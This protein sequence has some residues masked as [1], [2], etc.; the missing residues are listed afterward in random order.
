MGIFDRLFGGAGK[1]SVPS[2]IKEDLIRLNG[3]EVGLG[4]KAIAYVATG[5]GGT[6]LSTLAVKV[7]VDRLGVQSSHHSNLK[8]INERR[9]FLQRPL[10]IEPEVLGRYGEVLAASVRSSLSNSRWIRIIGTDEQ[11]LPLRIILSEALQV[12][13]QPQPIVNIA[14]QQP[15]LKLEDA[16]AIA[17][18]LGG[19]AS[20]VYAIL[21]TRADNY[22]S[23]T[24]WFRRSVKL[25]ERAQSDPAGFAAGIL[26]TEPEG[27]V[28][29]FGDLKTWGLASMPEYKPI[30][31]ASLGAGS[32]KLRAAAASALGT[33]PAP[34]LASLVSDQLAN[35]N[36]DAR[37]TAVDIA[38]GNLASLEETLRAH[39]AVEK[40]ARV[41]TAIENLLHASTINAQAAPA[42]TEVEYAPEVGP[43]YRGVDGQWIAIPPMVPPPTEPVPPLTADDR[44]ELHA[45][46]ARLNK[47]N[48]EYNRKLSAEHRKH[49]W[50]LRKSIS[51]SQV[52]VMLALA[53]GKPVASDI[54]GM[55]A[56]VMLIR[57]SNE[58][59]SWLLAKIGQLPAGR[60]LRLIQ[61]FRRGVLK[62]AGPYSSPD[63]VL[64][65]QWMA[66]AEG[67]MRFIEAIA[68]EAKAPSCRPW[69]SSGV[70]RDRKAARGD[71]L[72]AALERYGYYALRTIPDHAVWPYL[73][74]HLDIL[75]EAF[76]GNSALNK[77]KAV[78]LLAKLPTLPVQFVHP[79]LEMAT[80][81]SKTGKKLA[82]TLV[83]SVPGLP[84]R[85]C[86][87]LDESRQAVRAGAADWIAERGET[88]AMPAL[89]K[90]L[91]KEKSEIARGAIIRALQQ[92]GDPLD[93][94]I[95]EAALIAEAEKGVASGKAKLPDWLNL[96]SAP[97]VTFKSGK[98]V[99]QVV[100]H[101][102][103]SLANK[104]KDP[105]ATRL[106]GLWLDQLAPE[107][108]RQ[109]STWVLDAWIDWD[110]TRPSLEEANAYAS[111][112]A[113]AHYD[114]FKRWYKDYT[115]ELAHAQLRRERLAMM[116]NSSVDAKGLLALACRA[117]PA[118]VAGKVRAFLKEFGQRTSQSNS[119][120]EMLSGI[121]HPAA[122]QVVL[123]TSMRIKQKSVQ[124][125]AGD[126]VQAI[127][128][129][130]G[131]TI[132]E[133]ADRTI[134]TAGF[135][136]SGELELL[137]GEDAKRYCA[138]LGDDLTIL[139][140]NPAGKTVSSLPSG[141]DS[142]S[143]ESKKLLSSAR[144]ELKQVITLQ[145][146]RLYE[147]MCASR[148]FAA[149]D[150]QTYFLAHPIMRKL[151]VRTVWEGLDSDGN[152]LGAFRPTIEG[153][154]TDASDEA[155]DLASFASVRLAHPALMDPASA[156]DWQ[157]HLQD[158]EITQLFTQFGRP[159]H[160]LP[161]SDRKQRALT[162]R[163]G[164]SM[165]T[166]TLRGLASKL[167]Y[168]RG[169]AGDGG[170]FDTYI[171]RF[172][173]SELE[174]TVSFT[175]SP[176]P[177]ENAPCALIELT[178]EKVRA[179]ERW[180]SGR[181]ELGEVPPVL[182]SEAWNDWHQLASK[183]TFDPKWDNMG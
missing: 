55:G 125:R 49:H 161:E 176:L 112:N 122:L 43:G 56:V 121:D 10:S 107:G 104:M 178:F 8:I 164:W 150:W 128:D 155:V 132:E 130:R 53:S 46:V 113:K 15:I 38:A 39:L 140:E 48:E 123:A 57:E 153:D 94:V 16:L 117:R 4:E 175:G 167:G 27:Q 18:C 72:F 89:R 169:G 30:L 50:M 156:Q 166:F 62:P 44:Q 78:E 114:Q 135:D 111:A 131:W 127:A 137:I 7:T 63:E 174:A 163:K 160:K 116:P 120:L 31:V 108:A 20:D 65:G 124:A 181:V 5:E 103:L 21:Y 98:P 66:S 68:I 138:K 61:S 19:S 134:P 149:A 41:R 165:D 52:A 2:T 11:P 24:D 147:M 58:V 110:T 146:A 171:K 143:A 22:E 152:S 29:A 1:K 141:S 162:D 73:A 77:E 40:T 81:P 76:S 17:P 71:I 36:A 96:A 70:D 59:S 101:W 6:V 136:D 13:Y 83:A 23:P 75:A 85:L 157:T 180:S 3:V 102:W 154:L 84:D 119:L 158:Y 151:L 100:L 25:Q 133:L 168:E 88:S 145:T 28:V 95:G 109:F 42:G 80:G 97:Q 69:V 60:R 129:S 87:L 183:G 67:D 142:F 26:A 64:A 173:G 47:A 14:V 106:T 182:L 54:S 105:A 86:A 32:K 51:D 170:W 139:I 33:L 34:E 91:A 148:A 82:R 92:L 99:P 45:A 118:D 179:G 35:G 115:I 90:R 93:D 37:A 74:T 177:E 12:R 159:V 9:K 172:P 79:L 144:K 126:L